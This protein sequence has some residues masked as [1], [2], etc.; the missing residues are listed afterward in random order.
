MM[1]P[2]LSCNTLSKELCAHKNGIADLALWKAT[3][4]DMK[5]GLSHFIF[6]GII[7]CKRHANQ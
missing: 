2:F 5:Y 1:E 4:I 6:H 3:T 7:K